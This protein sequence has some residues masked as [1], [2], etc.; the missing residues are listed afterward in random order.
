MPCSAWRWR[1]GGPYGYQW[2]YNET[3]AVPE[4]TNAILVVSPLE[5]AAL[6]SYHAVVTNALGAVTSQ[7]AQ[8]TFDY[9][10]CDEDGMGDEWEWAHG[11]D[12]ANPADAD[13]DAD[14]D[15]L[16]NLQEA[17]IGTDPQDPL[18]V[19]KVQLLD[20]GDG[21]ALIEFTAMPEVEYSVE[22]TSQ[23]G[24][25]SWITL[26]NLAPIQE[27]QVYRVVDPEVGS[28][29]SRFYRVLA[30]PAP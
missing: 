19:L 16:T 7:V 6:G 30:P 4:G 28:D 20:G 24:S 2:Y 14:G 8:L 25:G 17:R 11:L 5:L 26:T 27:I 29:G 1:G 3:N 13:W 10:D 21:G 15:G 22:Y 12:P 18:S 9:G 23:L